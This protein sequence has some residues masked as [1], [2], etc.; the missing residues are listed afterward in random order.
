MSDKN[1]EHVFLDN[2]CRKFLCFI[3]F[4][5]FLSSRQLDLSERLPLL[6]RWLVD[7]DGTQL[8]LLL[9]VARLKRNNSEVFNR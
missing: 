8:L 2:F 4:C 9:V 7:D 5:S 3:R 1:V 6:L